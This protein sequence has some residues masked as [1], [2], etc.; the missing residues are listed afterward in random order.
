MQVTFAVTNGLSG[1]AERRRSLSRYIRLPN[2]GLAVRK[3]CGD[4]PILGTPLTAVWNA[5]SGG[6]DLTWN[7]AVDEL[8][9]ERDVERYVIW[10]RLA[11]DV[12]WGDPHVSL[13]PTG[14]TPSTSPAG[15]S[16]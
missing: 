6:V 4:E 10:R 7:A 13:S 2:V 1:A 14:T 5:T 12:A 9:G 3:T 11:S 8:A 16:R 15:R